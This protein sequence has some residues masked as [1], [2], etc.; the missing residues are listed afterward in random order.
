MVI[1]K[2]WHT[3]LHTGLDVLIKNFDVV[4]TVTASLLVV[5]AQ[6]V[7]QL[8]LDGVVVDTALTIQREA[9][10]L[11]SAAHMGVTPAVNQ[12][13]TC[14]VNLRLFHCIMVLSLR[15]V[16]VNMIF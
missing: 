5:E 2:Y 10:L 7:Q 3:L 6:S 12:Q 16:C 14:S 11:T 9:L 4:V 13:N 1:V 15:C 8:M